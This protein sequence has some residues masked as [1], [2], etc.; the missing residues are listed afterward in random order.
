MLVNALL[1]V[2]AVSPTQSSFTVCVMTSSSCSV[3]HA[4]ETC[5]EAVKRW[6]SGGTA[7]QQGT[8]RRTGG[9]AINA[10]NAMLCRT[11]RMTA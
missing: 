8:G 5:E 7:G 9:L 1:S 2:S 4:V 11:D 6:S 10:V 3:D